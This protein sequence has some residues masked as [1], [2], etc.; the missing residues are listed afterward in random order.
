MEPD[1]TEE[2]C[3]KT[4]A[5]REQVNAIAEEVLVVLHRRFYEA[6]SDY[7]GERARYDL[8]ERGFYH[9]LGILEQFSEKYEWDKGSITEY[10]GRMPPCER[11]HELRKE[12]DGWEYKR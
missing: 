7:V 3:Q 1:L 10:L 5:T 12:M 9:F 2:V 6:E 8:T 4:G 11:W